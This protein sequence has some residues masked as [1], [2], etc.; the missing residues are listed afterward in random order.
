MRESL[1]AFERLLLPT[2]GLA[3]VSGPLTPYIQS[4]HV[5]RPDLIETAVPSLYIKQHSFI[6]VRH[7]PCTFREK[8]HF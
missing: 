6:F 7:F 5:Q 2:I 8:I 1:T 4:L 3:Q